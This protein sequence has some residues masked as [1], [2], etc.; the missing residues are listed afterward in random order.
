MN[1]NRVSPIET[2][3]D[4]EWDEQQPENK[5]P[6]SPKSK[7]LSLGVPPVLDFCEPREMS[8]HIA[9]YFIQRMH[10]ENAAPGCCFILPSL[11]ALAQF[12]NVSC[13]D[14]Q[15]AL[16]IIKAKGYDY[17][18][19]GYYG[20]VSVWPSMTLTTVGQLQNEELTVSELKTSSKS[21]TVAF[22]NSKP[23]HNY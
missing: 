15:K 10:E 4:S 20:N 11:S 6:L 2:G 5:M 23:C 13:R 8:Y 22:I 19:P 21:W 18:T 1:V 17:M 16:K 3:M 7:V 12:L 14:I 9:L